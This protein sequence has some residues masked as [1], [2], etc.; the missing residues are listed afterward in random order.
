MFGGQKKHFMDFLTHTHSE[1]IRFCKRA[2]LIP[3]LKAQ[4]DPP[5]MLFTKTELTYE[6]CLVNGE[7]APRSSVPVTLLLDTG[8]PSPTPLMPR[9][10]VV[11]TGPL[12]ARDVSHRKDIHTSLVGHNLHLSNYCVSSNGKLNNLKYFS[13]L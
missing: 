3:N 10:S 8:H 11:Q 1:E 13:S 7:R 5:T 6:V 9:C 4:L 12:T 2:D